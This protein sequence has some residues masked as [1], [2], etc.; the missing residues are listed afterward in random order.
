MGEP[1]AGRELDALVAERVFGWTECDPDARPFGA[2]FEEPGYGRA[3]N[4]DR[5]FIPTYSTDI[6][7]AWQVVERVGERCC[8]FTLERAGSA[9]HADFR[10]GVATATT[11]PLAICLAALD[12]FGGQP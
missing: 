11:A 12:A 10:M 5:R 1:E 4:G 2:V 8:D 7:A 3:S 6:D 9:W